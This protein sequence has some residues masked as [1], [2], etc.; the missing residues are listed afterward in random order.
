MSSSPPF[1]LSRRRLAAWYTG[2]MSLILIAG[3]YAIYRLVVHARWMHLE[4]GMQQ[5]AIVLERRLQPMLEQPG[6]IDLSQGEQLPGLCVKDMPC[7][8]SARPE[9]FITQ[10]Q[11][12]LDDMSSLAKDRYCIRFLDLAG[13]PVATLSIPQTNTSCTSKKFWKWLRD[14]DREHYHQKRYPLHTLNHDEWGTLQIARSLNTLDI[15]LLGVELTLL[16][17]L[18][19]A[20]A[21]VGYAS[22]WLA[23]M[24]MQPVQQSY[25]RMQQFTADAAHELRTPVAAIR[26]MVQ[27]A[28]RSSELSP[29][30][31]NATLQTVDRQSQRLSRLMQDLLVLSQ[32][33]QDK[34]THTRKICDLSLLLKDVIDEFQGIAINAQLQLRLELQTAGPVHVL[35][36]PEQLHRAVAN[37]VSNG[38]Q[39]TPAGGQVTVQL[40]NEATYEATIRVKDTGVGISP[41]AQ[42]KI[43]DR[44]YRVDKERSRHSGGAGLGLAIVQAIVH[45]H[46]GTVHVESEPGRGSVFTIRL[47]V[48]LVL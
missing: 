47:P 24:A 5:M 36:Q 48:L 20:I 10:L 4:R 30:E 7:F 46:K 39:Y 15:Y 14:G 11:T 12:E 2:V 29:E 28:L 9:P 8:S 37:L 13:N 38:I 43:F 34:E 26:A 1:R 19:L 40:L 27:A 17:L 45:A 33:E 41:E 3:S 16:G 6:Q 23:G 25:E 21:L 31:V 32:L 22:W 18:L 44:F 42:S 35:G